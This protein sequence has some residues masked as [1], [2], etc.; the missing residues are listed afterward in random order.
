MYELNLQTYNPEFNSKRAEKRY[1]T[2][3][4][5]CSKMWLS[6][7]GGYDSALLFCESIP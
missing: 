3:L 5:A 2:P 1:F 4:S 7:S 6:A